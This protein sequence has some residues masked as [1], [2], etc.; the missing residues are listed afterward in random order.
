MKNNNK[1]RYPLIRISMTLFFPFTILSMVFIDQSNDFIIA[2]G[3]ILGWLSYFTGFIFIWNKLNRKS[4]VLLLFL[5]VLFL[6]LF[7]KFFD[8]SLFETLYLIFRSI[9]YAICGG[10]LVLNEP[11]IVYNQTIKF[12]LINIVIS[13]FQVSGIGGNFFQML[14]THGEPAYD[15]PF[16]TFF[17]DFYSENYLIIQERPAGLL[18][19][20]VLLSLF[21]LFSLAF[22]YSKEKVN[23]W[24]TTLVSLLMVL[25]MAKI[26]FVGF[27]LTGL[28]IFIFGKSFHK[29]RFKKGLFISIA[30]FVLHYIIFPG[31]FKSN[32]SSAAILFSI[33]IRLNEIMAVLL[34]NL[35]L[36][37]TPFFEGTSMF[38]WAEDELE[39]AS[40]IA[41]LIFKFKKNIYLVITLLIISFFLFLHARKNLKKLNS[42]INFQSLIFIMVIGIFTLTNNVWERPFFWMLIG[43]GFMP[44]VYYLKPTKM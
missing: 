42:L 26:S 10:V 32:L 2:I 27:V 44:F 8:V 41:L 7:A 38:T 5:G 15:V 6:K 18:G 30:F 23:K 33:F 13:F 37:N 43:F 12:V 34:P 19:A 4:I 3:Q 24:G 9:F 22:H 1:I 17:T 29:K 36:L 14:T 21:V 40:G 25:C 31:L 28:L 20:N 11:N 16:I 39:F 35:S